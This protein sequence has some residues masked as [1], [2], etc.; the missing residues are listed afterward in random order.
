MGNARS[1]NAVVSPTTS[2]QPATRGNASGAMPNAAHA[3]SDQRT[4]SR[5]SSIVREA[6]AASVT[7]SVPNRCSSQLSVVVMTPP[8]VTFSRSHFIFGAAKYGSSGRPV[9]AC[10]SL[11]QGS[12]R[13]QMP[14]ERRSCQTI[15]LL[16]GRPLALSQ[17]RTVSP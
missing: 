10:R 7:Y 13:S 12:R 3:G 5:S 1:V 15:A 11:A 2:A 4:A 6:V 17:A 8:A 9:I 16:S 14:A